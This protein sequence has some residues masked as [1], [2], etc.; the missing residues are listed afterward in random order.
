MTD[1][2]CDLQIYEEVTLVTRLTTSFHIPA[3]LSRLQYRK[4]FDLMLVV[5]WQYLYLMMSF[6]EVCWLFENVITVE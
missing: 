1:L 5:L 3:S 2:L 6:D 4:F